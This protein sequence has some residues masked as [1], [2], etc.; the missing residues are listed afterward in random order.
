MSSHPYYPRHLILTDYEPNQRSMLYLLMVVGGLL[1]SIALGSWYAA[2]RKNRPG[3]L[4]FVWFMICG[5][6]HCCFESYWLWHHT[7]ITSRTDLF[8]EL[9]KEY[10]HGDSR[11]LTSDPLVI[12]LETITVFVWGPLCFLSAW[13]WWQNWASHL[14]YQLVA[15]VGHLF[16]CS[17]YFILDFP[18]FANCDPHAF[19]FWIYFV[20]F[21]AP[22]ILVPGTV[23]FRNGRRILLSL[24]PHTSTTKKNH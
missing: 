11:Y 24:D 16:S 22:W 12:T 4:Y 1:G 18:D 5:L 6:L 13:A 15:S 3:A 17:L 23:I 20:A 10:A 8:A 7:D 19:Y 21:N 9:W 2:S 14:L